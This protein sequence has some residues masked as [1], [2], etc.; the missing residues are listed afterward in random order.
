[1]IKM[2]DYRPF[3][4]SETCRDRVISLTGCDVNWEL[5]YTDRLL[6]VKCVNTDRSIMII[7]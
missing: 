1:M 4:L 3:H 2:L 7:T 5:Y 6:K